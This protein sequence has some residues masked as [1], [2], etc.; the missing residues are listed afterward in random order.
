MT[1]QH[2]L[3]VGAHVHDESSGLALLTE[4][5]AHVLSQTSRQDHRSGVGPYVAGDTRQHVDP[6]CR[7]GFDGQV[8]GPQVEGLVDGQGE[9]RP[10]QRRGVV[11]QEQVVH[12][13]VAHQHQLQ[14]LVAGGVDLADQFPHQVV[15]GAADR[16]GQLCLAARVH[17][18]VGDSTHQVLAE[19][20]LRVHGSGGGQDFAGGQVAQ[21][22]GDRGRTDVDGRAQ[23]AVP[24]SR[25][26]GHHL[27]VVADGHGDCPVPV[28]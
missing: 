24:Q 1:G 25:P 20:D 19:A 27:A 15:E 9:R 4:A 8:V 6:G 18:H 16:A 11:A 21:V 10:A 5:S 17:H 14:H 3:G 28:S 2:D 26:H 23:Y 22:S 12:N 13:R 7:M